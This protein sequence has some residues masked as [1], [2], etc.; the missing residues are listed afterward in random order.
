MLEVRQ[1]SGYL[2]LMREWSAAHACSAVLALRF[3]DEY[4]T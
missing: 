2:K 1:L 3:S 4:H